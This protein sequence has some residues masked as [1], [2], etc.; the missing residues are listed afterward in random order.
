MTTNFQ[1][2][3]T[4]PSGSKSPSKWFIFQGRDIVLQ[5]QEEQLHIP[6]L[7]APE[8][9]GLTVHN[10]DYLGQLEGVN[11]YSGRI[12]PESK[13]PMG[14]IVV[15]LRSVYDQL[16][17]DI[18]FIA[19]YAYQLI[20]WDRTS[21]YCG[22]CGQDNEMKQ[23]ERAKECPK[24][25]LVT[26]PRLSPAVIMSVIKGDKILLARSARFPKGKGFFSVLAGFVEPGETLEECVAREIKEE[27][28]L[29][30]KNIRYFASQ[31]WP[32]PDSL[33]IGFTAEYASGEVVLE[34]EELAEYGWFT[35]DNLPRIPGS[36]SISRAI[37]DDFVEKF[38]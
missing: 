3:S 30:V 16:G 20:H 5:Q 4:P 37:I 26:Y 21:Y 19:G 32:F 12:A 22:R 27:V 6:E 23:G 13:L 31:P 18:F 35:A 29:E 25:H 9:L 7:F 1:K 2:L 33:M 34:E 8:D 15:G 24:C 14:H 38:S 36:I 28:N 17:N 10:I 11:C